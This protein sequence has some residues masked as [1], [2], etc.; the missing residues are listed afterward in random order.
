ME[1]DT[2]Y[3]WSK[4]RKGI[5]TAWVSSSLSPP[6]LDPDVVELH[7]VSTFRNVKAGSP[8]TEYDYD[9]V[10]REAYDASCRCGFL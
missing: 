9:S 7:F 8:G 10:Y 2:A 5:I 1:R 4:N 3:S 6:E